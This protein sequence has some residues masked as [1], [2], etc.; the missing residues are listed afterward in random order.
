M[1]RIALLAL[2]VLLVPI[3][4]GV[5]CAGPAVRAADMPADDSRYSFHRTKD[6]YVRLDGRTGQVSACTR[7]GTGWTCQAV[8]DERAALE[9]EI[10]RLQGENAALKKELIARSLPLPGVVKS[11]PPAKIEDPHLLPDA[12]VNKAMA[13]VEK[14][15]RRMVDMITSVQKGAM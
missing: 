1:N 13:F 9:G 11:D 10:A 4:G 12:E 6:G 8:A 7:K 2:L 5:A 3:A 15:W 14:V